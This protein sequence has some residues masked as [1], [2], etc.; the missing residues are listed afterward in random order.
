MACRGRGGSIFLLCF[1][2]L[3]F[4]TSLCHCMSL[5]RLKALDETREASMHAESQAEKTQQ[6]HGRLLIG[7]NVQQDSKFSITNSTKNVLD[8]ET[9]YQADMDWW[10]AKQDYRSKPDIK[11]IEQLLK[12]D[13]RVECTG[14]SMKLLVQDAALTPAS[15][16]FVDRGHLSPLSLSKLPLSCGYNIRS[17]QSDLVLI[18]PY[19]GCFIIIEDDSYVLPLRWWGL[20]V[21]MSC[22]L[23]RHLMHSP[24]MVTCHV[25]GMVVKMEWAASK[26]KVNVDGN[27]E[28]LLRATNRCMFSIVEH[29]EGVVISIR[30]TPCLAKKDG[31]YTL[32]LGGAGETKISCP[33]LAAQPEPTKPEE[34]PSQQSGTESRWL[35][36]SSAAHATSAHPP[37]QTGP[38]VPVLPP[39]SQIPIDINQGPQRVDRPQYP[40]YPQFPSFLYP[41]L[42]S[43]DTEAQQPK[44]TSPVTQT[45]KRQSLHPFPFYSQGPVYAVPTM[46]SLGT[47]SP[48][49]KHE[50]ILYQSPFNVTV[51][52]HQKPVGPPPS[53]SKGATA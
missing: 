2:F 11:A 10:Q 33:S 3:V 46:Q 51:G 42:T 48:Q 41:H 52:F 1:G 20:P 24:P 12:M 44:P 22:P 32:E 37:A 18:A 25:E 30:Y 14:D 17:T 45:G 9:D 15:L 38:Q 36:T 27:W 28:P 7:Q 16:L 50:D 5:T 53:Q 31:L 21:R 23:T 6:H 34:G 39:K 43:L 4:V 35:Y 40:Y 49:G 19:N 29:P 13:P 26:I 8:D 47:K